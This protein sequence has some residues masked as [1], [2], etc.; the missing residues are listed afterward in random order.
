MP[1]ILTFTSGP[2]DWKA[3][4][5]DPKKHWRSGFSARTLAHCWEASD[6]F[7]AEVSE[8]LTN[9]TEPLLA[10]LL[11]LLAVPEFT[12]PLAGGSRASQNDIFVL[13]RS[14][15]GP[16]CIMVEGK[17]NESFGPTLHEWRTDASPGKEKRL[18]FLVRTL[19]ISGLSDGN[20]RYQLLHRA[21]SAIITGEQYR[22]V[23][24]I[25]L[26]HSFSEQRTGWPD[27]ETFVSLFGVQAMGGV[28]QR[29]PSESRIPLFGAWVAGDCSFLKS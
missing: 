2:N 29:L 17:V 22:A 8:V 19:G 26:V 24:A 28:V 7:P 13:G 5:A 18:N 3:L 16:V 6:G 1:R 11:P 10:N 9:S 4:L 12:V 23:A 21:A 15:S 25:V 20:V 27:Y 14:A